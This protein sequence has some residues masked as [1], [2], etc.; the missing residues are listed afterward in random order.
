LSRAA[1]PSL[2]VH[3]DFFVPNPI[4]VS[5]DRRAKP[6]HRRLSRRGA[7]LLVISTSTS[8]RKKVVASASPA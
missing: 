3:V 5:E 2:R 4:A 8:R 6:L 7:N 1:H